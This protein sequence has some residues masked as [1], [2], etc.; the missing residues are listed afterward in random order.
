M[1]LPTERIDGL[2][3]RGL[4]HAPD[5]RPDRDCRPV[6]RPVTRQMM[7]P[8][9]L[10]ESSALGRRCESASSGEVERDLSAALDVSRPPRRIASR[11]R[12]NDGRRDSVGPGE[13]RFCVG[14]TEYAHR[15]GCLVVSC[16]NWAAD[17]PADSKPMSIGAT[18][19]LCG[20]CG[21]N[22][23]PRATPLRSRH[24]SG[25]ESSRRPLNR[26]AWW[27][28]RAHGHRRCRAAGDA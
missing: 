19:D 10:S 23:E 4:A 3:V 7:S 20:P 18:L 14:W 24:R 25:H 1:H 9:A 11:W 6:G 12:T 27:C 2:S 26:P 28:P 22:G 5:G 17:E 15:F 16:A 8:S 21:T 13:N